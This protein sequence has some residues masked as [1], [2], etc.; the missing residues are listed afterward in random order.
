M[1]YFTYMRTSLY[2]FAVAFVVGTIINKMFIRIQSELEAPNL[3]VIALTQLFCIITIA[4]MLS[5]YDPIEPYAPKF[6]FSSFL[7]SLQTNM[8]SNF[9]EIFN[10]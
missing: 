1:N 5:N 6:M 3:V 7:L 8:I 9:K 10:I 4:Y 2:V